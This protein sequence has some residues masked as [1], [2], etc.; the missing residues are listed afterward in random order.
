MTHNASTPSRNHAV[1]CTTVDRRV[2]VAR[3]G[4]GGK[5]S[6]HAFPWTPS[7]T[8][9]ASNVRA[10]GLP[11]LAACTRVVRTHFVPAAPSSVL[12]ADTGVGA[13]HTSPISRSANAKEWTEVE[14]CAAT[15]W[16]ESTD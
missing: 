7:C 15:D 12:Q 5:S 4:R 6:W 8:T 9:R 1:N 3:P 10:T 13:T 16:T 2:S 11:G 14:T